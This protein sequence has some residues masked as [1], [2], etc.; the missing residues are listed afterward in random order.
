MS[1]SPVLSWLTGTNDVPFGFE[2]QE[3]RSIRDDA[4]DTMR[5]NQLQIQRLQSK[6]KRPGSDETILSLTRNN[7]SLNQTV[8]RCQSILS[9]IRRIPPAIL[10]NIFLFAAPSLQEIRDVSWYDAIE[11][12]P[13]TLGHIC[14]NWRAVAL[15]TLALWSTIVIRRQYD[16]EPCSLPMLETQLIRSANSLLN[17]FFDYEH[18]HYDHT[19]DKALKILA[20]HSPRWKTFYIVDTQLD[21]L[22]SVRGRV[23]LLEKV[24][25]WGPEDGPGTDDGNSPPPGPI[26]HF[27]IAPRLRS[28]EVVH[29]YPSFS[30]PWAQLTRYE[31]MGAW[32]VH[33]AFVRRLENAESCSLTIA[34][35]DYGDDDGYHD[36][37]PVTLPKLR[38]LALSTERY[39]FG[40]PREEWI[41]PKWSL[42]G[43]IELS[44]SDA[45][46]EGV[47]DMLR[48]S[49]CRL[50][51]LRITAGCP[52]V[53]AILPLFDTNPSITEL[54][55][56]LDRSSAMAPDDIGRLIA[57]ITLDPHGRV[58]LPRL[59]TLVVLRPYKDHEDVVARMITSRF[60][61]TD[62]A[63]SRLRKV[64]C[65]DIGAGLASRLNVLERQ[66][67]SVSVR[68]SE[69]R[70]LQKSYGSSSS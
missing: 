34:N 8:L 15:K 10:S 53:A 27:A 60:R 39:I 30:L 9:P 22:P 37:R 57:L 63:V 35:D 48:L 45:L 62:P 29:C 40:S 51:K 11:Q 3:V 18:S 13:W 14:R 44:I 1:S 16:S 20:Q 41:C 56:T 58:V 61:M 6:D 19:A 64:V 65:W 28:A 2:A 67:L 66:G 42:P 12:S 24:G 5:R 54:S 33:L 38:R 49:R 4:Q 17:V 21:R 55:I 69:D 59:A 36:N 50:Q 47:P 31:S 46:L 70:C 43:L 26:A 68:S 52:S 7:A 23:P 25:V 32:S